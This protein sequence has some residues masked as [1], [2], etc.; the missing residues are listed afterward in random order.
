MPP[1]MMAVE[2]GKAK[3]FA[4]TVIETARQGWADPPP[5]SSETAVMLTV[6]PG[7]LAP[8]YPALVAMLLLVAPRWVAF[9]C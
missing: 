4:S 3:T 5:I 2:P 6:F 1:G 7:L 9:C 8:L